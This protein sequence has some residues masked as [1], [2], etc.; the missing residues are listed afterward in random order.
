MRRAGTA[1]AATLVAML[2]AAS[3]ALADNGEGWAGSTSDKT[4]TLA[5]FGVIAFFTVFVIVAS[6]I[7]G[8]LERRKDRRRSDHEHGS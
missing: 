6:L 5:C 8:R 1:F 2:V 7:Q 3:P 4:K